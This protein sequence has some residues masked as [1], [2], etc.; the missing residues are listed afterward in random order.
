MLKLDS[1]RDIALGEFLW[2]TP[3]IFLKDATYTGDND[4]CLH[5]YMHRK[6]Y[7]SRN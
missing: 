7:H 3:V 5:I 6:K 4:N 1:E 2:G